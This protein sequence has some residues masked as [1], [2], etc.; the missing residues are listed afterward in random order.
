MRYSNIIGS[1]KPN[2]LHFFMVPSSVCFQVDPFQATCDHYHSVYTT[3]P[4]ELALVTYE[5][6]YLE[7]Y[8]QF[9]EC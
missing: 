7:P 9:S 3:R 4:N 8:T 1:F 6:F 5:Y 2:D